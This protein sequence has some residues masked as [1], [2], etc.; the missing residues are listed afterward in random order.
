MQAPYFVVRQWNSV[1]SQ[2]FATFAAAYYHIVAQ[3]EPE[4]YYIRLRQ[5]DSSLVPIR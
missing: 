2:R 5:R 3:A 1:Y 4:D